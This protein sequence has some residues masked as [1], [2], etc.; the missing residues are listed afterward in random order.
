MS[1]R[2][3]LAGTVGAAILGI[4]A[5]H[6]AQAVNSAATVQNVMMEIQG[7]KADH[8]NRYD[9]LNDQTANNMLSVQQLT[10]DERAAFSF[11]SEDG[12]AYVVMVSGMSQDACKDLVAT[13]AADSLV[14]NGEAVGRRQLN[15]DAPAKC[16][17]TFW[18]WSGKNTVTLIGS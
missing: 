5:V 18:R 7:A 8:G 6:T 2:V 16:H 3:K 13:D 11:G 17:S 10:N 1:H 14:V 15:P 12:H 4:Y 9:W